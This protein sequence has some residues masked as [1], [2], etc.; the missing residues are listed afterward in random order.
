LLNSLFLSLLLQNPQVLLQ[1]LYVFLNDGVVRLQKQL[2][3]FI[4]CNLDVLANLLK[5]A[6]LLSK[7]F[8]LSG[9]LPLNAVLVDLAGNEFGHKDNRTNDHCSNKANKQKACYYLN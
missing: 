5:Q 8:L 3:V 7:C 4:C 6:K 9:K 1:K 2:P